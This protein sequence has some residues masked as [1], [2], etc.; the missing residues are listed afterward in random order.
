ML[1][2]YKGPKIITPHP[3]EAARLLNCTVEETLK[4]RAK[5]ALIIAKFTKSVTI[6]K[7]ANTIVA[8]PQNELYFITDGNPAM[9]T[10]GTGDMLAGMAASLLSQGLSARDSAILAAKLHAKAGDKALLASS[11]LSLT[12]TDMLKALPSTINELYSLR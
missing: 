6:L 5:S 1:R 4:N 11:L 10:A 9:A 12:P 7:G 8:T 3:K 2:D